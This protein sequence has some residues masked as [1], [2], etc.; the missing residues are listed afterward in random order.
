VSAGGV[1][2]LGRAE[3]EGSEAP[4]GSTSNAIR[5]EESMLEEVVVAEQDEGTPPP[6]PPS[7]LESGEGGTQEA[8]ETPPGQALPDGNSGRGKPPV[9]RW[10]RTTPGRK[11]RV[12]N[13]VWSGP[14]SSQTD[15]D[16]QSPSVVGV[17]E[18]QGGDEGATSPW[19]RPSKKRRVRWAPLPSDVGGGAVA[20]RSADACCGVAQGEA[21]EVTAGGRKASQQR[22][23]EAPG[24]EPPL[25]AAAAS[26]LGEASPSC[27]G[28]GGRTTA[29]GGDLGAVGKGP[30]ASGSRGGG[31]VRN[32]EGGAEVAEV[33]RLE[34]PMQ[35]ADPVAVPPP[36]QRMHEETAKVQPLFL[37]CFSF[38]FACTSSDCQEGDLNREERDLK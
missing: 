17:E 31:V 2:E 5:T 13:S 7:C 15:S 18:V 10:V 30:A 38:S 33:A 8:S 19:Q 9:V 22:D 32:E 6:S 23:A 28:G 35:Q 26:T 16:Y 27:L 36:D 3:G 34:P 24:E 11:Q 14:F 21:A 4:S 20:E 25:H 37:S 12:G 29:V 1:S